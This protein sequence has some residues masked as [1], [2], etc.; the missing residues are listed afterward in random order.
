MLTESVYTLEEVSQYLRVPID[1]LR[2]EVAVGRLQA[3]KIADLVRIEESALKAYKETA[4]AA[5]LPTTANSES[6][7]DFLKQILPASDFTHKWPDGKNE[8]FKNAQECMAFYRG[9][10]HHLKVGFAIRK[11]AGKNRLRVLVLVDRYPTVEFVGEGA[12]MGS[13]KEQIASVIKDRRGKHLLIG[14]AVPPEYQGLQIGPYRDVVVGP[15]ASNGLA[16]ICKSDDIHAMG[17]H[18]LIRCTYRQE[19]A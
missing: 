6:A 17:K 3:W 18:A 2:Q 8:D 12:E 19:R 5:P 14:A 7:D 4:K 11:A 16:V 9:R 1:I 15:N 10:E 13:G